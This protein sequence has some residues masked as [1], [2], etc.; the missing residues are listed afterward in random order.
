M[1]DAL[2]QQLHNYYKL[3]LIRQMRL[4]MPAIVHIDDNIYIGNYGNITDKAQT[5]P[6]SFHVLFTDIDYSPALLKEQLSIEQVVYLDRNRL[7]EELSKT[8]ALLDAALKQQKN[9]LITCLTGK[10]FSPF[11]IIC[12]LV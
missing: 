1:A 9:I 10:V 5:A 8:I 2:S 7:S 3:R 4:Q 6:L 12:Y 11:L